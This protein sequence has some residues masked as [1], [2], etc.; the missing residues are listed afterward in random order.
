MHVVCRQQPANAKQA[1]L[2]AFAMDQ[3]KI[4]CV[5][6]QQPNAAT[7]FAWQTHWKRVATMQEQQSA[8]VAFAV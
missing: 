7:T 6:R 4:N 8:R 1:R 2:D 3:W 5:A